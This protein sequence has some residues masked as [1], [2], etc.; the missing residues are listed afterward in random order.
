MTA[1]VQNTWSFLRHQ[2]HVGKNGHRSSKS[3]KN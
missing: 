1:D 3:Y 2:G